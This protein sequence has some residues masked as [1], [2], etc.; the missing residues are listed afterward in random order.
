MCVRASAS[1]VSGDGI[2]GFATGRSVVLG[3]VVGVARGA[4]KR[5]WDR[6]LEML[7]TIA[8]ARAMPSRIVR[9]WK[10]DIAITTP[11]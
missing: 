8:A 6:A 7:A 10:P 3:A 4:P 2:F 1:K 11:P 9:V 5:L